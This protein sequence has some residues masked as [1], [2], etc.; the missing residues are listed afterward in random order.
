[1]KNLRGFFIIIFLLAII[2]VVTSCKKD[3][4]PTES[5]GNGDELV[6][7]WVLTKVIISG[8]IEIAPEAVGVSAT[9]NLKSNRTFIISYT[10]SDTTGN[11]ENQGT[12]S[13]SNNQV[14]MTDSNGTTSIM[15]YTISDNKL[16][17]NTTFDL[18]SFG[19]GDAQEVE[20]ELTKQ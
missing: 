3:N 17:V 15:P 1:M 12:W 14:T 8:G 16:R 4:S 11:T 5:T 6:G 10:Y 7:T 9:F 13:V 2:I 20:L 19:Y 18:S